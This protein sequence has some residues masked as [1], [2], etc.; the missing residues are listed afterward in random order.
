[1]RNY[2]LDSYAMLAYF[3]NEAGAQTVQQLFS[4]S[5]SKESVLFIS[6][7]NLGEIAYI[8]RR[9]SGPETA[10]IIMSAV[11]LLPIEVVGVD[12]E[13]A[14]SAAE[15]KADYPISYADCFAL[16][17]AERVGGA[18]VTGDP[19]FEKVGDLVPI[20]WLPHKQS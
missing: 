4:E 7:I 3:Q 18:V 11:D 17:L 15:I 14:L 5:V 10:D 1:V 12:R 6:C 16:A 13:L 8:T 20:Q 9:K 19:E 2:V